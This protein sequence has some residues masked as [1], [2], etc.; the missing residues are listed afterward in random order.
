M[1]KRQLV[2]NDNKKTLREGEFFYYAGLASGGKYGPESNSKDARYDCETSVCDAT[3]ASTISNVLANIA[4]F[5][6][7]TSLI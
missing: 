6:L 7:N 1:Q 3:K 4:F 2:G 5:N